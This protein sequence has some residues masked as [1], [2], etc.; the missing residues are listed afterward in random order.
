M[1]RENTPTSGFTLVELLVVVL[2]IGILA[3][4][5]VPQY[6]KAVWKSKTVQLL[7]TIKALATAQE[8]YHMENGTYATAFSELDISLDNLPLVTSIG[9]P[10][11]SS[12]DAVRGN[13]DFE[14]IINT[15]SSGLRSRGQF[16]KGPYAGGG[17][18]FVHTSTDADLPAQKL[19]CTEVISF[20]PEEG[21]FCKQISFGSTK[22]KDIGGVRFYQLP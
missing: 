9:A 21:K 12:D 14:I 6:Q 7:T 20:F 17:Y 5:A 15:A 10:S 11:T 2:I 1:T 8:V 22:I 13:E 16:H 19:Y 4:V 3:A 18:S